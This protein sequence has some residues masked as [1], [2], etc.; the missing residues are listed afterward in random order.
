MKDLSFDWDEQKNQSNIEK[1]SVSF[2]EAVTVFY[3][4]R[5][6]EFYDDVHSSL[7]EDRFLMLGFSAKIRMLMVCYCMRCDDNVIRI[8]SARKATRPEARKYAK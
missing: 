3:D 1:H 7:G 5:A 6:I 4:D 2:E 8:I